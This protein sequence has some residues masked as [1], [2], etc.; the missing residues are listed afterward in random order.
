MY[1]ENC[2]KKLIRGY[3]FCIEC[4]TPVPPEQDEEETQAQ[5]EQPAETPQNEEMPRIK[6]L[7]S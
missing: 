1:C 2:G 3:Q 5:G 7:V 4:G 6:P